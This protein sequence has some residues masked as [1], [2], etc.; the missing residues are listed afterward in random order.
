M[1]HDSRQG[2]VPS[3]PLPSQPLSSWS[4][5][6]ALVACVIIFGGGQLLGLILLQ[7]AMGLLQG[8]QAVLSFDAVD[9]LVTETQQWLLVSIQ[10]TVT[11]VELVLAWHVARWVGKDRFAA[12][13]WLRTQ[14]NTNEWIK[15]VA[16]IVAVKFS[17]TAVALNLPGGSASEISKDMAP[18]VALAK[19]TR[20]W[21]CFLAAVIL[22]AALEEIVFRGILSRTLEETAL[23][24]VGGAAVASA[25]F[26]L[27]HLQYG[28]TGQLV[29]FALGFAFSWIR[30]RYGS[31]WPGIV[32]HAVNNA[33]ALLVMKA[34]A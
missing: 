13:N 19:D 25:I 32:A 26:A 28:L 23:G 2:L 16:L 5:S 30:A 18:I 17:A 34:I 22:A 24:F 21:L 10:I 20:L 11:I 12:V 7:G 29:V 33:F 1:P 15:I 6:S 27:L 31:I 14:L 3:V 9:K 4:V 8:W